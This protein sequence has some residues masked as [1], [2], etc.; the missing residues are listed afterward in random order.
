MNDHFVNIKVDCEERPD[1]DHVY[2]A[3]AQIISGQGGWP[4]TVFL[5][6]DKKPFYAGTY[7]P[8]QDRYGRPGFK[9][10]LS[11]LARLW[12]HAPEQIE[13]AAKEIS[14]ALQEGIRY[15]H[16]EIA[17]SVIS[18]D[19]P[20]TAPIRQLKRAYDPDNGGFGGAPKFPL[21]ILNLFLQQSKTQPELLHIVTESLSKM[22]Q[23]GICDQLG[24][25]FHRYSTDA[26]WLVPHFEKMQVAVILGSLQIM[27]AEVPKSVHLHSYLEYAKVEL[28]DVKYS[29]EGGHHFWVFPHAGH[30]NWRVLH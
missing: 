7:F 9:L 4:L 28:D 8:P 29:Q 27:D 19:L 30:W 1:I 11:E 23:G 6:P 25:G 17:G 3:A 10:V 13:E 14:E 5:T 24:G 26:R 12:E 20:S 15:N 16:K 22:A 21:N 2:Q 18:A